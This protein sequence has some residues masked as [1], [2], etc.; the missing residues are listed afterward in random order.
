MTELN[1]IYDMLVDKGWS[2]KDRRSQYAMQSMPLAFTKEYFYIIM[3]PM[4][5]GI[6]F[7]LYCEDISTKTS[8]LIATASDGDIPDII[9]SDKEIPFEKFMSLIGKDISQIPIAAGNYVTE[10][11]LETI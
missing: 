3:Q 1:K 10:T 7:V 6:R 9:K 5:R 8:Y 4:Y 11:L 2:C